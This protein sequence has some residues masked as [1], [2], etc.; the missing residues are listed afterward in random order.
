VSAPEHLLFLT[1]RLAETPLNRVLADMQPT[2]FAY[3]VH[4][5]GLNVAGLM[6]ADMV[7]RKLTD[8]FGAQRI[9]VPGRCRGDLKRIE[10]KFGLPVIRGPEELKDLPQFFGKQGKPVDL[11]GYDVLIFAEIVDAAHL[12]VEDLLARAHAHRNDG[13]DVIDLGCL[14][15]TP[16][17]TLDHHV[18]ALKAA[19]FIVSVD[20]M[21]TEELIRGSDAGADYLLSLKEDSIHILDRV[22]ATPILI[23]QTPDDLDSLL[24]VM[25]IC[26]QKQRRY[27]AD[28][29]LEPIHFGLTK[30]I[31]RYQR[32]RDLRPD[33]PM[34][35][36][37]GN[38]TELTHAD[39]LGMNAMLL[40]LCSELH[41]G[42][43]LT[44]QVSGHAASAI[45]E[46][47]GVRRVMYAARAQND[48]PRALSPALHALH[49]RN[50]FPDTPDEIA[51]TASAVRD[52]NYR[53]QVSRDGIHLY[54][55]DGLHTYG[56]PFAFY[57]HLADKVDTGHA[58]YLG[59]ELARAQIA[60]QLGKRYTQDQE[61][62]WGVATSTKKENLAEQD[63]PGTT[64]SHAVRGLDVREKGKANDADDS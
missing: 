64:L 2:P 49:E 23:G 58:F 13:A 34:M 43:I 17:P 4:Q 11:S 61:L 55:R 41:V 48:L 26:E 21:S 30:S 31:V 29:I 60:W 57:P 9:V 44:T 3:T 14:P 8:T 25:D 7:C 36:G 33:A 53:I 54:N 37:V 40:G 19:G 5:L 47:D 50:P 39:T 46:A 6:T 56:D 15:D 27:F 59:A 35:M 42:A 38:L 28:P 45:R 10:D 16:Y 24:R 62:K 51:A 22:R 52:P 20:S 63:A 1:G 32:L 18:K 12:R